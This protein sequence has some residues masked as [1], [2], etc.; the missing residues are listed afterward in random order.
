[1]STPGAAALLVGGRRRV[2][3]RKAP[4]LPWPLIAVWGALV[5]N[6]LAF[7]DSSLMVFPIPNVVGKLITQGSLVLA[8]LLVLAVNRRGLVAPN[9][10]LGLLSI[11]VVIGL[12]VS[13]HNEFI[14]GS[15]YRACRFL[16]FVVVLWLTTP[17]W[18]RRDM[19]ILRCHRRVLWIILGT[20]VVGAVLSPGR[21]FSF[22]GR[23][24]DVL[25]PI[26]PTGVA[27]VAA[28]LFGTSVVL[29]MCHVITGRHAAVA[30]VV[31]GVVLVA[32]H[33]R[34][35]V[36]GTM[37]GLAVATASLF[38]GHV[39]ARRL[40][41]FSAATTIVASTFFASGLT[42]WAMR[43]QS[44]YQASQFTGRTTAWA[45]VF[46]T[47]RPKIQ[48]L[49]GSGFSNQ[50]INGLPIDSSWVATFYDLGVVG[51]VIQAALFLIL[52]AMAVTNQR[53]PQR[54]VGLFLVGYVLVASLT[55]SGVGTP[56]PYLLDLTIAAALL[57]RSPSRGT[58]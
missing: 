12:V 23:L 16:C 10:F 43:G 11:L 13:T 18:G 28:I 19:L 14:V 49:F 42:T 47:Q 5:C 51:V 53:G 55:E 45:A 9:L 3:P 44:A 34:T 58:T 25:W 4:A 56:S 48:E 15:V 40:S 37:F 38:V 41:A 2:T 46:D 20:V 24:A 7:G 36:A 57:S 29:W 31:A 39:R 8:L 32:T 50:S 30:L 22:E 17:W 35:A 52:F 27:H 21:A 1:M 6:V 26:L 54:A 33:T